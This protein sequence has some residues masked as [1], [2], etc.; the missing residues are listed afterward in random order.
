[1]SL[2]DKRAKVVLSMSEIEKVFGLPDGVHVSRVVSHDDPPGLTVHVVSE[3]FLETYKDAEAPI[4][5]ARELL[6]DNVNEI[7]ASRA[8]F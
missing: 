2:I 7:Q 3:G 8:E 6:S 5:S 1:M 4:L